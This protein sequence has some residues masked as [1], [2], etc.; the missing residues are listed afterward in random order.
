MVMAELDSGSGGDGGGL[1]L[2]GFVVGWAAVVASRI[3][4]GELLIM[5]RTIR[6]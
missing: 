4:G 2:G 5:R 3:V 1:D 6:R